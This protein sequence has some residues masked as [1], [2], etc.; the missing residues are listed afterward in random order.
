VR[1]AGADPTCRLL[2]Y[3]EGRRAFQRL[4]EELVRASDDQ[5]IF[6]WDWLQRFR[7]NGR[8]LK[9]FPQLRVEHLINIG[10]D[11]QPPYTSEGIDFK[12]YRGATDISS[13][14]TSMF[15]PD[16]VFYT[17]SDKYVTEHDLHESSTPFFITNKGL[18]ISMLAHNTARGRWKSHQEPPLWYGEQA[19]IA[20][21]CLN[22]IDVYMTS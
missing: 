7:R 10:W 8:D 4:Q 11:V 16:P 18:S 17:S 9:E 20:A 14:A 6:V 13:G 12:Q 21:I 15:A 2:L 3:D 5:S 22:E 19:P 1:Q